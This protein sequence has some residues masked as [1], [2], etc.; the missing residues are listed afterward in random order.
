M[1]GGLGRAQPPLLCKTSSKMRTC[2]V[3]LSLASF[4]RTCRV[5]F[6]AARSCLLM[7]SF[8]HFFLSF[9]LSLFLSIFLSVFLSVFRS[10]FLSL[11]PNSPCFVL[12]LFLAFL[13]FLLSFCLCFFPYLH[14]S[15][16]LCLFLSFVRGAE[17]QEPLKATKYRKSPRGEPNQGR[18]EPLKKKTWPQTKRDNTKCGN[19]MRHR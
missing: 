3:L 19:N 5:L 11:K 16:V 4:A 12:S 18:A 8:L 14:I 13:H 17:N 15:F 6:K 2:R 9:G 10:L 1:S 7:W